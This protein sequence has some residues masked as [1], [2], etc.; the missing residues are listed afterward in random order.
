MTKPVKRTKH[1]LKDQ[2]K[3]AGDLAELVELLTVEITQRTEMMTEW[4]QEQRLAWLTNDPVLSLAV[5]LEYY[6]HE[7]LP[8][9]KEVPN[10]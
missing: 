8:V 1:E 10:V 4:S 6:L 7:T 3:L 2:Q 9:H 5:D